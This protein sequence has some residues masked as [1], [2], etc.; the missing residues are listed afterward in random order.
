MALRETLRIL[1]VGGIFR[2]VV[3]DLQVYAERYV[4]RIASGDATASTQFL[5]GTGLGIRSRPKGPVRLASSLFG[6]S[7]HQWMWDEMS[8][9]AE[10][11]RAGFSA[12]RRAEHGDCTDPMFKL[13]EEPERFLDA[14]A[15]E[16][17]R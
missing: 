3:P 5:D 14:C 12:I 16:A 10:L 15:M 6:G 8:L 17:R 9:R 11:H 4:S 13:V 2:L 7:A 1:V